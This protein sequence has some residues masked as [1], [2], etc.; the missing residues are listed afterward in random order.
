M[1]RAEG[2]ELNGESAGEAESGG[3]ASRGVAAAAYVVRP[4]SLDGEGEVC[5]AGAGDGREVGVVVRVVV[6][7]SDDCRNRGAGR[8]AV[9]KARQHLRC[10]CLA[11]R[12]RTRR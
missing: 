6:A 7:V 9:Q 2:E 5:V 4:A 1:P 8:A 10:V 12:G 11:A 3:E